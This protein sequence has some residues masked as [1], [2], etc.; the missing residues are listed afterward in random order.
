M[1]EDISQTGQYRLDIP[2][3]CEIGFQ[4]GYFGTRLFAFPNTGCGTL[5]KFAYDDVLDGIRDINGQLSPCHGQELAEHFLHSVEQT[6]FGGPVVV[7]HRRG[8]SVDQVFLLLT[9]LFGNR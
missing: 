2:R 4:A 3:Y 1:G 7:F 9:Q 8:K 5:R 6:L